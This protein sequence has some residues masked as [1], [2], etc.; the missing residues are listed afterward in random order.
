MMLRMWIR[1]VRVKK[2][3]H[4]N[5]QKILNVLGSGR[6]LKSS[7]EATRLKAVQQ[8]K[9][10]NVR[11][12][13]RGLVKS[14]ASSTI[15]GIATVLNLSNPEDRIPQSYFLKIKIF[16]FFNKMSAQPLVL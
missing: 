15:T 1:K 12:K 9:T 7:C 10:S 11:T 14:L 13:K 16:R 5:M 4:V 6:W 2:K 8:N 3:H